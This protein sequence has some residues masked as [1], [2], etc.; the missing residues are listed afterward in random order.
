MAAFEEYKQA[1]LSYLYAEQAFERRDIERTKRMSREE[2]IAAD[3]LLPGLAVAGADGQT[4]ILD[5][6]ENY[7]KLRSGDRVSL[8]T[9]GGEIASAALVVD[10]NAA[11]ITVTAEN[12]L[13]EDVPYDL[14]MESP[15]LLRSL[16]GC[17]EG[18]VPATPGTSFLRLLSGEEAVEEEDFLVLEP[19]KIG[20]FGKTFSG[21]N[22]PQRAAVRSMLKFYPVHVLQGPPGTGKTQVLAATAIAASLKDREVVIVANTHQAVNNALLKI[23]Q[24][25]KDIPLFKIGERLKAEELGDDIHKFGKYAEY[26]DYS[27]ENR[28]KKR[29]GYVLGMTIWGAISNLGLHS[30]SHFRPY[31]ALVDEASLMPLTYASIL[32]KCSSSICFFGDSCQMPP[33]F[34]K[35]LAGNDLSESVLDYCARKVEGIPVCVLPET[36]R[37]N[38]EITAVVSRSFY[39]PHDIRLFSAG[40]VAQKRFQSSFFESRGLNDSVAFMDASIST[41]MCREE[42]EGEA[43]AVME[44]LKALLEE[45]KRPGDIAVI[46]PFRKQVRLLRSKAN[47]AFP[48]GGI[49]LIDTV[50]RL[51]GQDVDCIIL[52]FAASDPTY[53]AT[54]H[55]FL[56]NPNRLNVMLSRAK[57][58]AVVF[59]CQSVQDCLKSILFQQA[60][61]PQA[62]SRIQ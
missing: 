60:R 5:A 38:D 20:G 42:N 30:H 56:F 9:A 52:S 48:P 35:E 43:S 4:Y 44:T 12:A 8:K 29:R 24:L 16:I 22:E 47:D 49:P 27:R 1:L 33:I 55:D 17:L 37:M 41:P 10:T 13:K 23:R 3:L 2:K 61:P 21:L 45:G 51:Q 25:D 57:T 28:R 50:E 58:K 14:E 15:N 31:I 26:N 46:T 36:H 39:E 59:A 11:T 34:R 54:M 32:G 18:I 62:P 7:S 19:E 40:E 53:I 6:P